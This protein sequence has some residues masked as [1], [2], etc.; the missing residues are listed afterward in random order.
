MKRETT[1]HDPCFER[2]AEGIA[3]LV[4]LADRCD[5]SGIKHQLREMIEEYTPCTEE[6][7]GQG[8][9]EGERPKIGR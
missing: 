1:T 6:T 4:Q 5:G 3:L 7:G 2:L 8:E 9:G